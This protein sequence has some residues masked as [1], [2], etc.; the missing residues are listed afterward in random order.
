[1]ILK[2]GQKI[3]SR[4]IYSVTRNNIMDIQTKEQFLKE[5]D[6]LTKNVYES[7]E[8]SLPD[9]FSRWFSYVIHCDIPPV[10]LV[11]NG[12]LYKK[13]FKA[14]YTDAKSRIILNSSDRFIKEKREALFAL[15]DVVKTSPLWENFRFL[16]KKYLEINREQ[17]TLEGLLEQD[18]LSEFENVS[19][20]L[21]QIFI[22]CLDLTDTDQNV[23]RDEQHEIQASDRIVKI[24]HNAPEYQEII[25]KLEELENSIRKSNSI[26]NE[27]KDRLQAEL[28]AGEGI[29][30]GKTARIE[31]I[32][33]LL[34]KGLKYIIEHVA[35]AAIVF[36]AEY[37]LKLIFQYFNLTG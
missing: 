18:Y 1:M 20:N 17:G 23:D 26:E 10:R 30:K 3:K 35:N 24:N 33:T 2:S 34:V 37:L 14:L 21:R 16:Q 28:K 11:I 9:N 36:T 31:V 8:K 13:S 32:K 22:R 25:E 29:L 5:Y 4:K 27:D 7:N 6:K 19:Q 15:N 12:L